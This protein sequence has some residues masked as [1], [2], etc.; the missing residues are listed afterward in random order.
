M[1]TVGI[2]ALIAETVP[3]ERIAQVVGTR[4]A[5]LAITSVAASL[6]SGQ[7]LVSVQFPL[8]YQIVFG[9]GFIGAMLST[10]H[11]KLIRAKAKGK[12]AGDFI[13]KELLPSKETVKGET[14][15]QTLQRVMIRIKGMD[16]LRLDI[17]KGPFKRVILLLFFFH[18]AQYFGIPI[19]PPSW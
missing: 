3:H 18:L 12:K 13:D 5:A 15:I 6:I 16:F 14:R 8:N 4:N 19:F 2:N 10:L 7:I 9:I 11:L 1:V 17:I